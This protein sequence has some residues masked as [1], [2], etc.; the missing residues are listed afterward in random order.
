MCTCK[1]SPFLYHL[2]RDLIILYYFK[3]SLHIYGIEITGYGQG[4]KKKKIYL[5]SF[6]L[7]CQLKDMGTTDLHLSYFILYLQL[8]Q[9]VGTRAT[10]FA[11]SL[12]STRE[13]STTPVP[14]RIGTPNGVLPRLLMMWTSCGVNAEVSDFPIL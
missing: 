11:Y 1:R 2:E 7:R 8:R 14:L 10:Q 5:M 12:L 6:T 4:L 9:K 3:V 13:L